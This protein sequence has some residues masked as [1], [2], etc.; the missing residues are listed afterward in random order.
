M[1]VA[2][3][4]VTAVFKIA[5]VGPWVLTKKCHITHLTVRC[6]ILILGPV[7]KGS[8]V[9]YYYRLVVFE[10]LEGRQDPG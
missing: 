2:P 5:A 8:T 9:G 6:G 4:T 3:L 10:D 7:V 1:C